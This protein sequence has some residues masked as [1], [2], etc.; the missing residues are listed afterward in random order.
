MA[1]LFI[2]HS[3]IW[4]RLKRWN[5]NCSNYNLWNFNVQHESA[6]ET[7]TSNFCCSKIKEVISTQDNPH[8]KESYKIITPNEHN[9]ESK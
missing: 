2:I 9:A 6:L 5:E 3:L 4:V 8:P 1:C 7:N